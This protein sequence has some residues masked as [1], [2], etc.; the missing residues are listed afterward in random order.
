MGIKKGY[1]RLI[2]LPIP[3]R[4]TQAATHRPLPSVVRGKV[5]QQ[6]S[7]PMSKG[8]EVSEGCRRVG[9]T[10]QRAHGSTDLAEGIK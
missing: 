7:L 10:T 3:L 5:P 4:W 8:G 1:F 2:E 6:G 9:G